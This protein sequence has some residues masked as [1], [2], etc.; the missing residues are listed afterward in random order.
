MHTKWDLR[1]VDL[2]R[3]LDYRNTW[4]EDYELIVVSLIAILKHKER[5]IDEPPLTCGSSSTGLMP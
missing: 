4:I 1:H 5:Q 2:S 3:L